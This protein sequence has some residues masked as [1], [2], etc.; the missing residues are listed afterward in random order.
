MTQEYY[1]TQLSTGLGLINETKELLSLYEDGMTTQQLINKALVCG[2]FPLI[3]A[4]R[5]RN[6]VSGG[7]ATRYLKDPGVA[8]MLKWLSIH[9]SN[10]EFE[11][12]LFI[13]T[14]RA[15][16]ILADFIREVYWPRYTAGRSEIVIE[17]ARYFVE[18]SLKNGKMKKPWS[19]ATIKRNSSYLIGCCTD[20]GLLQAVGRTK[21]RI[22]PYRMTSKVAAFLVYDL[23]FNGLSDNQIVSHSDWA[24]FGLD[25][26]DVREQLK[27]LSLQGLLIYQSAADVVHIG[28]NYKNMEELI[29]VIT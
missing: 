13:Y 8:P 3:S 7:F 11:Q 17:D 23:K 26:Q 20:Y 27:R 28:W 14:S 4:T 29:N 6:M 9:L 21:R 24:L 1:T 5:L 12:L 10:V 25:T 22:M 2:R 18:N 16:L 15:N 19:D